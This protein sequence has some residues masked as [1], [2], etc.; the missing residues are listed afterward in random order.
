MSTTELPRV[1]GRPSNLPLF[2]KIGPDGAM[3]GVITFDG[4]PSCYP[5]EGPHADGSRYLQVYGD[6]PFADLDMHY[7]HDE[8][9]IEAERVIRKRTVCNR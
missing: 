1:I 9:E 5:G 2:A 8:Y 4:Q 7:F 6:E 3:Q